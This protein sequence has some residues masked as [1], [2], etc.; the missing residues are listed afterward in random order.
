MITVEFRTIVKNGVVVIP[1]EHRDRF[2]G[3]VK[4]VLVADDSPRPAGDAIARLLAKPLQVPG[5]T[6]LT[7]DEAHAR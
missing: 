4:V 3:D 2:A 5:F 7:R 1:S 6:P